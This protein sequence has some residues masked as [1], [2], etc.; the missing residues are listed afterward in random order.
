MLILDTTA[1]SRDSYFMRRTP[2]PRKLDIV[3]LRLRASV[4]KVA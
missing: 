1:V 2:S 3:F 4:S